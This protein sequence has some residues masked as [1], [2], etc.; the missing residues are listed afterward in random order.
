V[1]VEEGEYADMEE[2]SAVEEE[3]NS[4]LSI[5]V[6]YFSIRLSLWFVVF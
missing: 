6:F 1:A 4:K 3:F 5:L 2:S